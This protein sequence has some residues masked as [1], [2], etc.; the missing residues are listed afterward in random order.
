MPKRTYTDKDKATVWAM[1]TAN[2]GNVSRTV[3]ETGVPAST[4][5]EW[6][7]EWKDNPPDWSEEDLAPVHEFVE[8]AETVR[9]YILNQY[10]DAVQRGEV[11]AEK[12]PVHIAI[13]DDKIRLHKGMATSRNETVT[14]LPKAEELRELFA[15]FA[16]AVSEA[17]RKREEI[18]EAEWSEQSDKELP[19]AAEV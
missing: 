3:R 10:F 9:D 4:I 11:K 19:P 2:E 12:L 17:A 6:R 1:L 16:S 15:G 14:T 13:F 18:I 7:D 5:R 8:K